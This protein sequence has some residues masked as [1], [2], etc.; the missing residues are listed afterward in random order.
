MNIMIYIYI[1]IYIIIILIILIMMIIIIIMIMII[2]IIS[3]SMCVYIYIYIYIYSHEG[4][5]RGRQLRGHGPTRVGRGGRAVR[6]HAIS[7]SLSLSIYIYI[8]IHKSLSLS[9]WLICISLSIDEVPCNP[10]ATSV[11][12][13]TSLLFPTSKL[14]SPKWAIGRM[15]RGMLQRGSQGIQRI[16]LWKQ[17]RHVPRSLGTPVQDTPFRSP[18]VSGEN[19]FEPRLSRDGVSCTT[20]IF[21]AAT[22]AIRL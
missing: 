4:A 20:W 15:E 19:H 17:D 1:Y 16:H 13:G 18:K 21:T 3:I 6:V 8:C 22:E 7:I 11:R 12:M 2:L 10:W 5:E 9:L 14:N